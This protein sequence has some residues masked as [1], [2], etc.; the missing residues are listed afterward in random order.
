MLTDACQRTKSFDR[1]LRNEFAHGASI[2]YDARL[3]NSQNHL[4]NEELTT[5]RRD[6]K[7]IYQIDLDEFQDLYINKNAQAVDL[8]RKHMRQISLKGSEV[9][10]T[11]FVPS[12]FGG[13]PST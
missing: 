9:E 2:V 6:F 8:L 13:T 3:I 1:H 4:S 11:L 12:K 5:L 7:G 10:L